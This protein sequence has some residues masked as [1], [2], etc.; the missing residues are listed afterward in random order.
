[1]KQSERQVPEP[2]TLPA[3]Q[4]VP[5]ATLGCPQAPAPSHASVVHALSSVPQ[6][7]PRVVFPWVQPDAGSQ[8][9]V[10]HGSLSLQSSAAPPVQ[11]PAWQVSFVEQALPSLHDVPSV[12]LGFEHTPVVVSQVP[13]SWHWSSA[14]QLTP[15]H[16]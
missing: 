1:M 6:G 14:V 7:T 11:V 13:A 9:S 2:Q 16:S 10:V 8:L 3:A 15:V 5:S 4:A 12:L